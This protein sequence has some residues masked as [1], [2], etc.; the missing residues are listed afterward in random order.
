MAAVENTSGLSLG[1]GIEYSWTVLTLSE[2]GGVPN[3][4]YFYDFGTKLVYY[5]NA[6]GNIIKVFDKKSALHGEVDATNTVTNSYTDITTVSVPAGTLSSNGDSITLKFFGT[7]TAGPTRMLKVIAFGIEIL[8][9]QQLN[10]LYGHT[11]TF[12]ATIYR[13]SNNSI[14]A[15]VRWREPTNN[16]AVSDLTVVKSNET[17][18][19]TTLSADSH[20]IIIK[21]YSS[22]SGGITILGSNAYIT[23]VI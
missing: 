22:I 15:C 7:T 9:E 2:S 20:N 6:N 14:H 3:D 23:K 5:K 21:G 1:I 8:S 13:K 4:K 10:S 19:S 12:E 16:T 11:F 17:L 18:T